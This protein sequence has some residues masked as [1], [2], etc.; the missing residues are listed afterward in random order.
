[1]RGRSAPP[2]VPPCQFFVEVEMCLVVDDDPQVRLELH[3]LLASE[4]HPIYVAP[5]GEAAL[6]IADQVAV[7]LVITDLVMPAM[8]GTLLIESLAAVSPDLPVIA[9]SGKGAELLQ[10][11]RLAGAAAVFSKPIDRDAL[12]REVDR[13][14][15][16]GA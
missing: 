5:H 2:G 16:R 15:R 7:D 4:G 13:V 6:G 9:I 3:T 8:R 10:Q 11:A 14:L 12:V 1:M